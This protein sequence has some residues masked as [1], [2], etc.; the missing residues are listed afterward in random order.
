M[1]LCHLQVAGTKGRSTHRFVYLGGGN[2]RVPVYNGQHGGLH[3]AGIF[4]RLGGTGGRVTPTE[5]ETAPPGDD[6]LRPGLVV[7]VAVRKTD[8]LDEIGPL[9][10]GRRHLDDGEVVG[11]EVLVEGVEEQPDGHEEL[12]RPLG[13]VILPITR[14]DHIG[15]GPTVIPVPFL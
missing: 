6:T 15:R 12:L 4:W 8:W 13:P 9:E 11:E 5:A 3:P 2:T 1:C 7:E 10:P 14:H